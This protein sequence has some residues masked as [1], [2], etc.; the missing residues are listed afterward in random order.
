MSNRSRWANVYLPST[1][2]PWGIDKRQAF[3]GTK[4]EILKQGPHA[5]AEAAAKRAN[6]AAQAMGD[7]FLQPGPHGLLYKLVGHE[8]KLV[9]RAYVPRGG[10]RSFWFTGRRSRFG[11][12][13]CFSTMTR[14]LSALMPVLAILCKDGSGRLLADDGEGDAEVGS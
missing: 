8:G 11:S 5:G 6:N 13:C 4:A 14:G 12:T 1:G 7:L 2:R 9:L 3:D 10:L